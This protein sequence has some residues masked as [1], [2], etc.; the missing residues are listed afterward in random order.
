MIIVNGQF[1]EAFNPLPSV[2]TMLTMLAFTGAVV[3]Y[4]LG[5]T[6]NASGGI[7]CDSVMVPR[8]RSGHGPPST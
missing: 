8:L 4:L 7:C 3:S 5:Q 6:M 1:L 2:K